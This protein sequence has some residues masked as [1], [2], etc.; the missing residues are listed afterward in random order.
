[1][2][3]FNQK[4][5]ASRSA[6]SSKRVAAVQLL[7]QQPII[8]FDMESVSAMSSSYADELFGIL[9]TELGEAFFERVTFS[10]ASDRVLESLASAIAIRAAEASQAA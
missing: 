5:L 10:K 7:A 8:Q 3:S 1:M 4:V 6:A 9:Y 2:I